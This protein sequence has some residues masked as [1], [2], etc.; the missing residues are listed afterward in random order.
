[1]LTN[2]LTSANAAEVKWT[3]F[4][5]DSVNPVRALTTS[6]VGIATAVATGQDTGSAINNVQNLLFTLNANEF[7]NSSVTEAVSL[8]G[9]ASYAGDSALAFG[10]GGYALNFNSNGSLANNSAETGLKVI[11]VQAT[12]VAAATSSTYFQYN[13]ALNSTVAF[14]G[15][16]KGFHVAAVP[17]PESLAMLLAGMG[18]VGTM[19]ARRRRFSA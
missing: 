3:I 19:A 11:R 16:D 5:A 1:M 6:Q 13:N 7:L 9:S 8:A 18:V 2:W 17:E 10:T 4:A 14:V 15:A 12:N